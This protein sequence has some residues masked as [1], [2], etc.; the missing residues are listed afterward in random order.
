MR[1]V[2][3]DRLWVTIV[4]SHMWDMQTPESDIDYFVAERFPTAALLMGYKPRESRFIQRGREDYTVHEI[5]KVIEMLLK[6]N[7]NFLFGVISPNVVETSKWHEQLRRLILENPFKGVYHS[8]RG[9]AVHNYKKYLETGRDTS[10]RRANKILRVLRF[11]ITL[12]RGGIYEF[13]PFY[14]GTPRLVK[15]YIEE[16]DEAYRE[17]SLPEHLPEDKLRRLL[18]EIRM[19]S[20]LPEDSLRQIL[21]EMGLKS[22]KEA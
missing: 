7:V 10:E 17:S 16:L 3:S 22:L 9:M 13:R 14:G 20:L 15:Q 8:I 19:E 2:V 12:L 6:G 11:G 18:Y 5:G 21:Y 4:G 1:D